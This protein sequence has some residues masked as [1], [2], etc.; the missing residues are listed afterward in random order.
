MSEKKSIKKK[1]PLKTILKKIGNKSKLQ[2]A[3]NIAI[4]NV[5]DLYNSKKNY[6]TFCSNPKYVNILKKTKA[7]AIL[8]PSKFKH[9]VP[10]NQFL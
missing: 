10:K 9:Y 6:L 5:G 3:E 7:S 1:I 2:I 4:H 8:I